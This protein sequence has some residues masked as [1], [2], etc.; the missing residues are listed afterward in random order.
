MLPNPAENIGF[1]SSD[2]DSFLSLTGGWGGGW[3][4]GVGGMSRA[5]GGAGGGVLS[6]LR[7]AHSGRHGGWQYSQRARG[8]GA[9]DYGL[10]LLFFWPYRERKCSRLH[11]YRDGLK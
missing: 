2:L 9:A 1:A 5:G 11:R 7:L 4:G 8:R 3:G 10:L 6:L